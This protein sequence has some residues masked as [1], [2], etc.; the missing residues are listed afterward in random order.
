[1][2]IQRDAE[3]WQAIG[4]LSSIVDVF[5][6]TNLYQIDASN[7]R[8]F[9]VKLPAIPFILGVDSQL[10]RAFKKS[11]DIFPRGMGHVDSMCG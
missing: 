8:M 10:Y 7:Y 6:T 9:V 4:R 3:I 1:M 5:R 2:L 11:L